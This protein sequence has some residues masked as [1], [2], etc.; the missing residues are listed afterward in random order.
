MKITVLPSSTITNKTGFW[1]TNRPKFIYDKCTACGTCPR[2]CPEGIIY[3]TDKTNLI[4]KK[5]F[6]CD[7]T[8]CKGCG[9]CAAECPFGAI[10]MEG[11]EK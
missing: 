3:Q 11:E 6:A 10:I 5:Y 7:L 1:R 2:T 8:F 4:G 9:L